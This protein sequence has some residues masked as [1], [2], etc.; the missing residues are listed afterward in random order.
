VSGRVRLR[1]FSM[2]SLSNSD[3]YEHR[4]R[5]ESVYLIRRGK[6]R[7]F[8]ESAW[9]A[10]RETNSDLGFRRD[11]KWTGKLGNLSKSDSTTLCW[12]DAFDGLRTAITLYG[13]LCRVDRSPRKRH[14]AKANRD[15][16]KVVSIKPIKR[17]LVRY[18]ENK[19]SGGFGC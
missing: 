11:G 9:F 16:K 5:N 10:R 4:G 17:A 2:G 13:L 18:T 7:D 8:L 15:H 1:S 3:T 6:F 12:G 14:E 19:W